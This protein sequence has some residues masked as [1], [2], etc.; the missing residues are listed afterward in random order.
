MI[1]SRP[2]TVEGRILGVVLTHQLGWNLIATDPL[3]GDLHGRIFPSQVEASRIVGL[4]F[5]RA[6]ALPAHPPGLRPLPALRIIDGD[7]G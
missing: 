4:V 6:R 5:A 2:V 3:V 1:E 7:G